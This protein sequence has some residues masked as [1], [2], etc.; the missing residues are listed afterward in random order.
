MAEEKVK[1]GG[2]TTQPTPG[3]S[4]WEVGTGI[5]PR[6]ERRSTARRSS[7]AIASRDGMIRWGLASPI[8]RAPAGA[9]FESRSPRLPATAFT[10]TTRSA[11]PR[12][13]L[14]SVL[15]TSRMS[16][17]QRLRL[18][19]FPTLRPTAN[20]RRAETV[21]PEIPG[22]MK[23]IRLSVW[24]F[25]PSPITRS[26]SPL[27]RS[28]AAL[29]NVASTPRQSPGHYFPGVVG[30]RTVRP[31]ARRRESTLRPFE[32]A[33]RALNPWVRSRLIRLG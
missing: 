29:G 33:I 2:G 22:A 20:P 11:P 6:A 15:N 10:T 23:T 8:P 21:A 13:C 7:W 17:F 30:A 25:W 3:P 1:S 26:K 4:A 5:L 31:L 9:A 24:A 28:R 18:T 27:W 19:A 12:T 14:S 16:R 32:V